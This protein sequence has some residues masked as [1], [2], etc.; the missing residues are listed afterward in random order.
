M[1]KV[2]IY[3]GNKE[4]EAFKKVKE[5]LRSRGLI[6]GDSD[7]QVVKFAINLLETLILGNELHEL[8]ADSVNREQYSKAL[9]YAVS[10]G[11][12]KPNEFGVVSLRDFL[13]YALFLIVLSINRRAGDEYVIE[14]GEG[15]SVSTGTPGF[16]S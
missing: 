1:P 12:L 7:Y 3:I 10:K 14:K 5:Y 8:F 6:T 4:Y 16:Y 2:S 15:E 13:S 9:K 11:L